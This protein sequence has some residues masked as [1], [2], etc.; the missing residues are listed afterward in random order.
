MAKSALVGLV[1]ILL[2][3]FFNYT[4]W[5]DRE[6]ILLLP[7]LPYYGKMQ[8]ERKEDT[9]TDYL[10]LPLEDYI[11]Y[12]KTVKGLAPTSIREYT[13][14]LTAFFRFL[15]K[16]KG[17]AEFRRMEFDAIPIEDMGIKDIQAASLHDLQA[18]L[19]FSE[20]GEMPSA[21]RRARKT[22]AL[23]GF[24]KYLVVFEE[25]LDKNPM[26]KLTTPKKKKRQPVY[27]TL[28]EAIQLIDQASRE[29]NH[30]FRLRDV[31]ILV[32][33]LTTGIRLSELVSLNLNS[34]KDD[35]FNV[36][37]K[38]DKE[39]TVYITE[40]LQAALSSYLSVRPIVPGESALFLSSRKKRM[41][42]RAVQHR[43]EKILRDAG[44]DTSRYSVH[45]LRHTAA[46]LMYK[47]GVDIRTLQKILG[48][49]S[50]GTTQIYTHVDDPMVK[51]GMEKN[52]LSQM[53]LPHLD[54]NKGEEN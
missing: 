6:Q 17:G 20:D 5:K 50:I 14:D 3:I 45:K 53:D 13:Y 23:R 32:T 40:A 27:L 31:A 9:M 2:P 34:L 43:I 39:R 47:E 30:F 19:A 46:T 12:L 33:F 49:A 36:I 16:R 37:G 10:P 41:S 1:S 52:P 51:Q 21:N 8:G 24:F 7:F 38:G 26:D 22:S 25:V 4:S 29:D 18:F 28:T 48:H 11:N 42:Q 44:F 15:R 54:P 35:H